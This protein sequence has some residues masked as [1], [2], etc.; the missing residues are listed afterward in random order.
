MGAINSVKARGGDHTDLIK[1]LP[2]FGNRAKRGFSH[3]GAKSVIGAEEPQPSSSASAGFYGGGRGQTLQDQDNSALG[4]KR[5]VMSNTGRKVIGSHA[6]SPAEPL[7]NA[8]ILQH[9]DQN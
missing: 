5:R 4:K 6:K 1:S 3:T 2:S 8:D 9:L 7:P